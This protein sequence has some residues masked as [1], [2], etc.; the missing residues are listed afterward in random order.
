MP[1][2]A[3]PWSLLCLFCVSGIHQESNYGSS[4]S[5]CPITVHERT[6]LCKSQLEPIIENPGNT[7]GWN[8]L[9]VTDSETDYTGV[10]FVCNLR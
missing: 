8:K 6:A 5:T 1:L 10:K 9:L 7:L 4:R 2:Q 3:I